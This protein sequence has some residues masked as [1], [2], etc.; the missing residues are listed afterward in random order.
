VIGVLEMYQDVTDDLATTRQNSL[1]FALA[2]SLS[3]GA[4]LFL[5]V[6]RADKVIARGRDRLLD[7]QRKLQEGAERL[8]TVV[9]GAPVLLYSLDRDGV[10]TL[11]EGKGLEALGLQPGDLVGKSI[12]EVY[13]DSPEVLRDNRRAL[14]GETFALTL[15]T[16]GLAFETRFTP[17]TD[18]DGS[19]EGIICVGVDI[20]DRIAAE[21]AV[22][23]SNN[24][25][26]EALLELQQTQHQVVQQERL[27]ALGTMA[28]G[29]AHDSN[30]A[31]API[32]G[33]SDLLLQY[34]DTLDDREKSSDYLR[35]INTSAADAAAVVDRLREFYRHREDAIVSQVDLN[36][37]VREVI[38]MTQPRWKDVA[39]AKGSNIEFQVQLAD[40]LPLIQGDVSNLRTALTNL[41]FN[42]VDAMPNGGTLSLSTIALGDQVAMSVSDTGTGMTEEIRRR[43]LE[44]F[45]T[46]KAE[47]GTGLGL[48]MVYGIV[49]RHEGRID[50]HSGLGRGTTITIRLPVQMEQSTT[51]NRTDDRVVARSLRVL[52]ANDDPAVRLLIKDFLTRDGHSVESAVDGRE[53]LKK[54]G[55]GKFDLVVADRGMPN[56]GGDQLVAA[57]RAK[58]E[59]PIIMVT[60]FGN[61]MVD[62]GERPAGVDFCLSKPLEIAALRKAILTVVN[63]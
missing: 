27:R 2:G 55:E 42:S 49:Q 38:S 1:R 15:D 16:E 48:A 8:H 44:P 43:A 53:A 26:E 61:M 58:S 14:T 18:I 6:S 36:Q 31:L 5:V 7:Q 22:R 29:I 24:R 50:I 9:T 45:F 21:R 10:I 34:P 32:L 60:G 51:T 35:S 20:T 13:G 17:V 57:I 59:V 40:N 23:D 12:S 3:M 33:Y 30:N 52:V 11:S 19:A 39:Q 54:F 63:S 28:S 4:F 25:L 46:T 56:L 37:I 62:S 41:V 47:S